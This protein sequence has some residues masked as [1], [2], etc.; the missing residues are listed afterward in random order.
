MLCL[1]EPD[2]VSRLEKLGN[3]LKLI[4]R[5]RL[6]KKRSGLDGVSPYR[7]KLVH[8]PDACAKAK[9]GFP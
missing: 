8:R 1:N 2:V 3:R 9:G 6:S 4:F 5:V 7:R